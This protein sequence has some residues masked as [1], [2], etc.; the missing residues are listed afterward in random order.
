MNTPTPTTEKSSLCRPLPSGTRVALCVAVA[1]ALTVSSGAAVGVA[2][3]AGL[4][5]AM[6][7]GARRR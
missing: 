5:L 1:V 2:I 7:F 4:Y 6:T 3:G